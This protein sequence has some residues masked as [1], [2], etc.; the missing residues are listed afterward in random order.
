MRILTPRKALGGALVLILAAASAAWATNY[1]LWVNGRTG[2][3]VAGNYADFTYWGPATTAA[4]IN[5]KAVNWDG[6]NHISDQ[7]YLVRN[8]LDC[9]C[10]GPNWCYVAVHSAG[11]LMMG[12]TLSMYGGS[13]R[14][15]KNASPGSDGQCANSDGTT[16][17]GWNIKWVNV[18]AGAAGGS[19]LSDAGSWAMSEPLVA[20]LKT[21]TARAMY[22]HN[23]T[24]AKMFYM[25]AGAKGTAYSFILPGQ[26]DEA[27]A[28]HSSGG[29]SGSS[30]G[31][32]CNPS[33]WLC[34]DLTLGT[35]AVEGGRAKWSNHSV[36][37]RDD[38]EAYN[39]Y[40]NGNWGGVVGKVRA[41]MVTNAN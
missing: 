2:G 24:R 28:Y 29:V 9:Y 7:N 22:D 38:A 26:D 8:A 30:G 23:N 3:G 37:F 20:D 18:A 17:T 36:V 21:S 39:H 27:V 25:Y 40:T 1:S 19:E 12:Y 11:N 14:Y 41:D 34:N 13:S 4:G 5:K 32:Y 15:K 10:T 35:A 31:S 33:D 6:Y 16:Q